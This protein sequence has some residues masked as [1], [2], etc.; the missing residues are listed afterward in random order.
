MADQS[1]ASTFNLSKHRYLSP[2]SLSL[3]YQLQTSLLYYKYIKH[4]RVYVVYVVYIQ[5]VNHRKEFHTDY[6]V[7]YPKPIIPMPA[8]L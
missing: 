3:L 7:V 4:I 5:P 1:M 2:L 8:L 6:T